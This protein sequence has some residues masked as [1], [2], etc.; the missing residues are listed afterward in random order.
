M[1]PLTQHLEVGLVVFCSP[2]NIP[3]WREAISGQQKATKTDYI[4]TPVQ[5][6]NF[7]YP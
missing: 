7:H 3:R 4:Y 5:G 1:P 2:L 6:T